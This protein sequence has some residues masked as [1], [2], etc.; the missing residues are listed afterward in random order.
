[1]PQ[2]EY[3]DSRTARQPIGHA[4][5]SRS[6]SRYDPRSNEQISQ[7][8]DA[9]IKQ[10]LHRFGPDGTLRLAATMKGDQPLYRAIVAKLQDEN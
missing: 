5:A 7:I 3:R 1:M 9:W 4:Y 8:A 2:H 6:E 10:R